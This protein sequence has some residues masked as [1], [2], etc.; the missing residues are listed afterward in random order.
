MKR[1][2][3]QVLI[4]PYRQTDEGKFEYALFRRA[5]FGYWQPVAGGG[6]EGESIQQAAA[7]ETLEE[8]GIQTEAPFIA[9]QTVEP[10]PVTEFKESVLWGEEL[11][12]IPQYCFGVRAPRT[13]IKLSH[14]HTHYEWFSFPEAYRLLKF[15]GNRT[16]LWELD[17]RLRGMGP[18]AELHLAQPAIPPHAAILLKL[19]GSLITDKTQPHTARLEVLA[20]LADEIAIAL[21]EKPSLRLVLGHGSG[22]FGHVPAKKYGTRQGV[23]SEEAWQGFADVWHEANSLNQ[24][25]I[26]ALH[27]AGLPAITFSPAASVTA[28]NGQIV[29]WNMAPLET[30]L[31]KGLLPVVHG[32]VAF[33]TVLGGTILSTEDLFAHLARQLRPARLLLAGLE[34]GVWENYPLCT[35]LI[36]KITPQS[37]AKVQLGLGDSASTDVT[38][39]MESKVHQTLA[40]VEEIPSLQAL[41]FSGAMPGNVQ[42]AL[43]GASPGTQLTA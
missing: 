40:L 3:F 31:E 4:F 10:I 2:P 6:Q 42:L 5:D 19:G 33:D 17:C 12:I 39:G 28:R 21:S 13:E 20:R 27:A 41:I 1:A 25:V 9:L 38:G 30:A 37:L 35:R 26:E 18:R 34:E 29:E 36:N 23:R 7:R 43:L 22:S 15:E 24:L 16:A 32:D 11:Y 14:E 8:T